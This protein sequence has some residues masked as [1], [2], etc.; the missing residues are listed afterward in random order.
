MHVTKFPCTLLFYFTITIHASAPQA[1][2][3]NM[4]ADMLSSSDGITLNGNSTLS[5]ININTPSNLSI[6]QITVSC[7]DPSDFQPTSKAYYLEAVQKI[8][9]REDAFLPRIFFL[10]PIQRFLWEGGPWGDPK[11]CGIVIG[12]QRPMFTDYFP[13]ILIAHV[14]ALI[15][16]QCI[17]EENGYA[18]GWA[19]PGY[20]KGIVVVGHILREASPAK[21]VS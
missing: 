1:Q 5:L 3:G 16:E 12:N 14:A 11:E 17:N 8:L 19:S 9:I 6:P 10:S 4:Y 15:A 21:T 7:F 20:R 13:F 2:S 18:G